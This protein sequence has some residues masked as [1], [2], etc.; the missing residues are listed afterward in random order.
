[1]DS[2]RQRTKGSIPGGRASFDS[3]A[4]MDGGGNSSL[5]CQAA[6]GEEGEEETSVLFMCGL[7]GRCGHITALFE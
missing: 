7:K 6:S 2:K 4:V 1:M 3:M 5:E